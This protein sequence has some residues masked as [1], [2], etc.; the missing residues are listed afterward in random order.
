MGR[1][2]VKKEINKRY[3]KYVDR[4]DHEESKNLQVFYNGG[5]N[6]FYNNYPES[7]RASQFQILPN[8]VINHVYHCRNVLSIDMRGHYLTR[9]TSAKLSSQ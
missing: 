6:I 3:L 1:E 7:I 8:G 2:F 4:L 5:I 9:D